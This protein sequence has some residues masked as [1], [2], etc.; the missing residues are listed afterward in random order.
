MSE[1]VKM[2]NINPWKSSGFKILAVLAVH[3]LISMSLL[4][5]S[6]NAQLVYMAILAGIGIVKILEWLS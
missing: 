6:I 5:I 4:S 1:E 2:V 3:V